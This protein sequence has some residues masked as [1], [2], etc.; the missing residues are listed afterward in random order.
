MFLNC[1]CSAKKLTFVFNIRYL[2]GRSI[3]SNQFSVTEHLRHITIGSGRGLPGVWF[4]YE[5]SPIHATFEEKKR[6]TF[7]EFTA[8]ICAILGGIFTIF[9]V[10]DSGIDWIIKK[11]SPSELGR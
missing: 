4:F 5:L 3:E 8:S 6:S 2:N 1:F 7:L 10:I 11:I 9:G